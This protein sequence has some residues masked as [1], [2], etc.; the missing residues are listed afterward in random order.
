[1]TRASKVLTVFLVVAS[2]AFMGFA[3]TSSMTRTNNWKE[4]TKDYT[5]KIAKQKS[6]LEALD[7]E[8]P[9]WKDRL[10]ESIA[11]KEKDIAAM[12]QRELVLLEGLKKLADAAS[13]LSVQVVEKT[14][15]TQKKRDEAAQRREEAI[16]LR[17][18]LDE[19]RTQKEEALAEQKRLTDLLVQAL[20]TKERAERRK[21]LLESDARPYEEKVVPLP[22]PK[23][24]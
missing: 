1:M 20:G 2:V 14:D 10:T 5:D 8:I 4:Q 16:A 24:K 21:E 13:A 7:K 11:A 9:F 23:A 19:L 22:D 17:N 15:A 18:Q 6:E 3:A 12:Q